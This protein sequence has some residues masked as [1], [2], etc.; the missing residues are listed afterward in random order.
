MRDVVIPEYTVDSDANEDLDS[1]ELEDDSEE[2]NED[3]E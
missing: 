1:E 2:S 3:E